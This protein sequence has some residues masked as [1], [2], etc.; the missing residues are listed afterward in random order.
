[1]IDDVQRLQFVDFLSLKMPRLD[2]AEQTSISSERVGLATACTIHYGL[3]V[4]M[5]IRYLKGKYVGESGDADAILLEV[6][7]NISSKD[8]KHIKQIIDQGCPSHLDFEEDYENKHFVLQKRNQQTF[9][10]YPEVTAKTMN[11]EEKNS[12]VLPFRIWVI[13]FSPFC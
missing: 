2:H 4:G 7:P 11:K 6:S 12:H 10:Q 3:N 8:C 5:V 1:M 13:D 9:L